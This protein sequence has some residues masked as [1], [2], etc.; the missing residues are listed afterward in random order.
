MNIGENMKQKMG[1]RLLIL[2]LLIS[3]ST[4]YT[5]RISK[6]VKPTRVVNQ[7]ENGEENIS[8]DKNRSWTSGEQERYSSELSKKLEVSSHGRASRSARGLETFA[9]GTVTGTWRSRGPVN[10]PGAWKFVE[11]DE[12]T[13]T[14]YAVTN[15]HYGETQFIYKGTLAGDDFKILSGKF[16]NRFH[17][18][19]VVPENGG[20]RIIAGT[21][22]GTVFYSD[23]SGASWSQASGL[24][25]TGILS[26]VVNRQDG[27]KI[28]TMDKYKIWVSDDNGATFS[29]LKD[30][31]GDYDNGILYSPRYSSQPGSS[32]LYL[33]RA[34]IFYTLEGS[35]FSKLGTYDGWGELTVG[36]DSRQFYVVSKAV[37]SSEQWFVSSNG[38]VSW[39]SKT[40]VGAEYKSAT[41][42]FQQELHICASPED[43]TIVLGGYTVPI[44]TTDALTSTI[45]YGAYWGWYQVETGYPTQDE[46]HRDWYHPDIAGS[47]FFYDKNNQLVSLRCTDGGIYRSYTEWVTPGDTRATTVG[48]YYNITQFGDPT[49]EAYKSSIMTGAKNHD[50][51][52]VGTQDQGTQM[53]RESSMGEKNLKFDQVAYG[54][55]PIYF[56]RDGLTG[57]HMGY[58]ANNARKP[59]ALYSGETFRGHRNSVSDGALSWDPSWRYWNNAVIDDEE[60]AKRMWIIHEGLQRIEYNGS[61][62]SRTEN[63]FNTSLWV[64]AFAQSEKTPNTV[65]ALEG[66]KVYKSTNRGD[67]FDGGTSTP[68]SSDGGKEDYGSG[69]GSPIDDN[70]VL[71]SGVSK[72]SVHSIISTDGGSTW[73]DIT[74]IY[75][76]VATDGMRGTPDGKFVIASTNLGPY[77]FVVEEEKWYDLAGA[78]VPFFNGQRVEY[79]AATST[80]RFATWG[81]GIWDFT[82]GEVTEPDPFV[83]VLTPNGGEVYRPSDT[84]VVNWK[85]N[86][87]EM[88]TINLMKDGAFIQKLGEVAR[89]KTVFK[90]SIPED[91]AEG[92]YQIAVM[93]SVVG[94]TSDGSFSISDLT[95]LPQEKISIESVSSEYDQYFVAEKTLDGDSLSTWF[96]K[97]GELPATLVFKLDDFYLLTGL[98]ITPFQSDPGRSI[99]EYSIEVSTDNSSWSEVGSGEWQ[100]GATDI[101]QP[102]TV[103][104]KVQYVRF[105]INSLFAGVD[106]AS[107]A[108]FNLFY[109]DTPVGVVQKSPN[110]IH[111]AITNIQQNTIQFTT[112]KA[113]KYTVKIHSIDGRLVMKKTVNFSQ[114]VNRIKFNG[115]LARQISLLSITGEGHSIVEKIRLR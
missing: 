84:I 58:R 78:D 115:E 70:I 111:F 14:L 37:G 114:G 55:G 36:G 8:E 22:N 64:S 89:S 110:P 87:D 103:T 57:W 46:R 3:S 51:I 72:N 49:Q 82:M 106:F 52:F 10:M 76:N 81:Q 4:Y 105:T 39:S 107:I 79:L 16:P 9:N 104:E 59:F 30:F 23:N 92:D 48:T 31:G 21:E 56:T 11:L 69:W 35:T 93:T 19:I 50:H 102:F 17:D 90:H 60:P 73:R 24:P 80:F 6:L 18:L 97:I 25:S 88:F 27:N 43:P 98:L 61:S 83:T 41:D 47:Y 38:G 13:D 1:Y 108:E 71:F 28:Y 63:R 2:A 96:S 40:T 12:G 94:D 100:E 99:K 113:G 101:V 20:K 109:S 91:F 66:G 68:L 7:G 45:S 65:W 112:P 67:S 5:Q 77:I 86:I 95:L 33:A 26:T 54:D 29:V 44:L 42:H 53:I 74:G 32:N 15:G 62:L 85:S 75:P 34:G